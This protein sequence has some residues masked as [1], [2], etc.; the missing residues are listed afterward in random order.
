MW[1][2]GNSWPLLK[3][4][5]ERGREVA[6]VWLKSDYAKLGQAS[7]LDAK[8]SLLDPTLKHDGKRSEQRT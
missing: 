3:T 7:S 8:S 5:F 6:D 4:L 1:T 2:G